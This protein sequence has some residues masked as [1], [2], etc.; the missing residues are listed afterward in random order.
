MSIMKINQFSKFAAAAALAVASTGASAALID[1]KDAAWGTAIS[2]PPS[3]A[4]A[5]VGGVTLT[6]SNYGSQ[7]GFTSYL[8]WSSTH[9]VGIN[10]LVP[11][12][13]DLNRDEVGWLEKLTITFSSPTDVQSV[14]LSK[15]YKNELIT[16]T[17]KFDISANGGAATTF[18]ASGTNPFTGTFAFTGANYL[19]LQGNKLGSEASVQGINVATLPTAPTNGE[20]PLPATLPLL[21]MGLVAFAGL[22]RRRQSA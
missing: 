14:L 20:V 4:T 17:E 21:G 11:L 10:T 13:G 16:N 8:T 2:G 22:S 7:L 19:E 15:F 12:T 5:T 6:A 9:G 18:T 1:F 3:T